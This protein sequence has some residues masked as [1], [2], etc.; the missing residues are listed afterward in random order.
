M[1]LRPVPLL[2]PFNYVE[3]KLKMVSY[4]ESHDILD[5]SFGVG[6]QS[7]EDN[8]WIYDGEREYARMHMLMT[9]NMSYLM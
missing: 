9:P 2:S 4:I 7:Y 1:D 5:M 6:K 8:Y 3:W